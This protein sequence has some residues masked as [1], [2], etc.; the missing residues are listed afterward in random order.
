MATIRDV[1]KR[2]GVSIAT[3]SR[4]L[5]GTGRCTPDTAY[6]VMRAVED[7]GYTVNVTAKSLK[8]GRTNTIGIVLEEYSLL[9]TPEIVDAVLKVVRR[10]GFSV[11]LILGTDMRQPASILG[12]GRYDGLLLIDT[13]RNE[14]LLKELLRSNQNFVLLDGDSDRE[15][16][17]LVEID[18]FG[19]GYTATS[20]LIGLGHRKILFLEDN[21]SQLYTQELKR[22]YLFALDENG[23]A[24]SEELLIRNRGMGGDREEFGYSTLLSVSDR[25]EF[26]AVLATH[27][28]IAHGITAAAAKLVREIPGALSVVGYGCRP[29]SAYNPTPLTTVKVPYVQLGELG[30]EILVNNI[31]RMDSIVKRVKLQT[32]LIR[33]SSTAVNHSSGT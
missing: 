19:G 8:M 18:H 16:I 27:D 10:Q 11:E 13:P 25:L 15:D 9:D 22:G 20:E 5:N 6:R 28:R 24:Y 31:R 23:I 3:V 30:A 33:R 1:A 29:H 17:N 4:V 21:A 7:L 2:A 26:T 32:Q 12:E 14:V